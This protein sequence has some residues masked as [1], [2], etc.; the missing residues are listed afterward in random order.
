[1][2][3]PRK[4]SLSGVSGIEFRVRDAVSQLVLKGLD[5]EAQEGLSLLAELRAAH[6]RPPGSPERTTIVT[7]LIG[8]HTRALLALVQHE[9]GS[10]PH[11]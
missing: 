5:L 10:A 11:R 3:D 7:K 4:G 9:Q 2:D 6:L 8:F 1:M